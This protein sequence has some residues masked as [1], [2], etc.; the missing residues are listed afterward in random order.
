VAGDPYGTCTFSL[1]F[2]HL[3]KLKL[4][5]FRLQL[6][7]FDSLIEH[8]VPDSSD[9]LQLVFSACKFLDLTLVL[10]T[11]DFQMFVV[12]SFPPFSSY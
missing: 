9:F 4:N 11:E 7:L 12:L 1:A 10:Q 3:T 8:A 5:L 2:S 6:R